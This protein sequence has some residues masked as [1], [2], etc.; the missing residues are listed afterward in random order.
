MM[1]TPPVAVE[2]PPSVRGD[3]ARIWFYM[4]E[5]YSVPLTTE[6]RTHLARWSRADPV[7]D[8]QLLRDER[9]EAEQFRAAVTA[10][11]G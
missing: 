6:Q 9:I 11:V 2:P 3:V 5:I 1:S 10:S 8:W 4:A 7:D